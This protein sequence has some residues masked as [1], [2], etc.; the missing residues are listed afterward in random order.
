MLWF[1]L[2]CSESLFNVLRFS[3]TF[4]GS[5]LRLSHTLL[6]F[7]IVEESSESFLMLCEF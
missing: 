7:S 2:S 6:I 5:F 4:G 1:V 3:E